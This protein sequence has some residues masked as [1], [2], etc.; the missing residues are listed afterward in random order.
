LYSGIELRGVIEGRGNMLC[1]YFHGGR[2][3]WEGECGVRL[4][5]ATKAFIHLGFLPGDGEKKISPVLS[6]MSSPV[7]TT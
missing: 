3:Q 5:S 1:V 6:Q 4:V 7:K 2:G